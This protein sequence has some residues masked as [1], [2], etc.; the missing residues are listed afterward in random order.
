MNTPNSSQSAA[1]LSKTAHYY[2]DES[3]DGRLFGGQGRSLLSADLVNKHFIL[4][5]IAVEQP[6]ALASDLQALRMALLADSYYKGVPSMRAD[7]GKTAQMF[8]AKD[9]VP[10][11]RREVYRLLQKHAIKLFAVVRDMR[12]VLAIELERRRL[13]AKHRYR[14]DGLY[15][16][17]VSL[18]FK[19][20]LHEYTDCH[21]C[22]SKR[23][24]SDRTLA[25]EHA[26]ELAR[27]RSEEQSS[28]RVLTRL[29]VQVKDSRDEA[30]LQAADYMIWALQRYYRAGEERFMA[31]MWDKVGVIHAVDVLDESPNG[32]YYGKKKPLPELTGAAL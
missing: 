5:M 17:M 19:E 2:V 22:F 28:Q 26:L 27:Q 29:H 20:R 25:F 13:D 14:P 12:S 31:A 8:H 1:P 18:L 7:G 9:D 10:E 21:I 6:E 23:G 11:V 16:A 30:V 15:D 24:Q 4:G 3:G 32:S